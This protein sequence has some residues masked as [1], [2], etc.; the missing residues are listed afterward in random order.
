MAEMLNEY[1]KWHI[2]LELRIS[3]LSRSANLKYFPTL[4][5]GF[6]GVGHIWKCCKICNLT[7]HLIFKIGQSVHQCWFR[8]KAENNQRWWQILNPMPS[9]RR[10]VPSPRG[11]HTVWQPAYAVMGLINNVPSYTQMY[12]FNQNL[13]C[14]SIISIQTSIWT[15][16]W[17]KNI[18]WGQIHK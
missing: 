9:L 6:V 10:H 13:L 5:A 2:I 7:S 8:Q 17:S 15:S 1:G 4:T 11:N 3:A 14:Y 16:L 18:V 12:L